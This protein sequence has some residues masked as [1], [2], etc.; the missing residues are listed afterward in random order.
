MSIKKIFSLVASII[1][2]FIIQLFISFNSNAEENNIKYFSNDSGILSL[3]YHRF[4]EN[5]YP[6][7]NIRMEVFEKQIKIN[8]KILVM[9][10]TILNFS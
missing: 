2:F 7:T 9:N 4:N 1:S 6:S 3:M 10:F 5:K 8:Q